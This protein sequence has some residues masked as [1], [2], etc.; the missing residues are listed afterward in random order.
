MIAI[1]T[2]PMVLAFSAT[3]FVMLGGALRVGP[4]ALRRLAERPLLFLRTL[5]AIWIAVPLLTI[6]MVVVL[7]LPVLAA[8]T[9]LLMSVC[10]GVPMLLPSTKA[11]KGEVATAF[12][13]LLLAAATE[14]L[15]IPLWTRLL[16]AL[17]PRG[18][19]VQLG[20][21]PW[22]VLRVLLPTVFIPL[23]VGFAI[24]RVW[25]RAGAILERFA[26]LVYVLTLIVGGI[27][28]LMQGAPLLGHIAA[29][30]YFAAVLITVCDALIGYWAGWPSRQDQKAIALAAALGNPAL[31]LAVVE[32]AHPGV[33]AGALVA[34]YILVRA[35]AL[36]PFEWWLSRSSERRDLDARSSAPA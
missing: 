19:G 28:V 9:L 18:W 16:T 24:R 8:S 4:G 23:L 15:M 10:P 11:V 20:V 6:S 2:S 29:R 3:F 31:A 25:P 35:V 14:P 1:V 30:T 26:D 32:V 27:I 13:V 17:G 21:R 34:V 36:A 33:E 22:H 7:N 5:A 12:V